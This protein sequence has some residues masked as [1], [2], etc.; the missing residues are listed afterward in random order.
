MGLWRRSERV[1][2]TLE[3]VTDALA[4]PRHLDSPLTP[5]RRLTSGGTSH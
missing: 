2:G 1:L 5:H 4:K 3:A